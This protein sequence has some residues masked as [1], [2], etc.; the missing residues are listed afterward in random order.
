MREVRRLTTK[1]TVTSWR[2][3]L[4]LGLFRLLKSL[5]KLHPCFTNVFFL[6]RKRT[7]FVFPSLILAHLNSI[8]CGQV[9]R[10]S[11]YSIICIRYSHQYN[12]LTVILLFCSV[13]FVLYICCMSLHPG[14]GIPR[15]SVALPEDS[16]IFYPPMLNFFKTFFFLKMASFRGSKDTGCCSLFRL[17][18]HWGSV[19]WIL[20][21]MNKMN[22]IW[23]SASKIHFSV[24]MG[25]SVSWIVK[26]RSLFEFVF[27]W[28]C[29]EVD[30]LKCTFK[31]LDV[32]T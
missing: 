13:H 21:C 31:V 26:E 8:S 27:I 16:S 25:T 28:T 12:L 11:D 24:H 1:K 22:L 3:L 6:H 5:N 9:N 2:H 29:G 32:A 7:R 17:R 30:T 20:G 10:R 4:N 23:F 19:I 18:S 15:L 14:R